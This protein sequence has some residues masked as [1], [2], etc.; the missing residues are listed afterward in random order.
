M[1]TFASIHISL[2]VGAYICNISKGSKLR[3]GFDFLTG[4][5]VGRLTIES[6]QLA[7][8]VKSGQ[9]KKTLRGHLYVICHLYTS[10]LDS[11]LLCHN[12]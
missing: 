1:H 9:I 6:I 7:M 11:H 2:F 12:L 3:G 4:M 5:S 10:I 8:Y